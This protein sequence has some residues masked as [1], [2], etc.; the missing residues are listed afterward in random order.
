MGSKQLFEVSNHL[1]SSTDDYA[2]CAYIKAEK[3]IY[4]AGNEFIFFLKIKGRC[5]QVDQRWM[6]LYGPL[7][8]F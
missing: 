4:Y 7:G 3:F 2:L 1:P 8:H 6:P 5:F